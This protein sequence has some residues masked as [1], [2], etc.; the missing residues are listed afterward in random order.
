M[1]FFFLGIA[2]V[3]V[4]VVVVATIVAAA[5]TSHLFCCKERTEKR[6]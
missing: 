2:V 1:N 4:G 6:S 3:R 5:T